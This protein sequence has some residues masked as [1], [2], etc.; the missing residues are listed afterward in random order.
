M[1]IINLT[2][3]DYVH[4]IFEHSGSWYNDFYITTVPI[5][6]IPVRKIKNGVLVDILN[7]D[8]EF[9]E[10]LTSLKDV[11]SKYLIPRTFLTHL[12]SEVSYKNYII[13]PHS[14]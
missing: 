8:G 13:R 9:I 10:T 11:M 3:W 14:K 1:P 5:K 4:Q 7:H 6:D 12:N 2:K